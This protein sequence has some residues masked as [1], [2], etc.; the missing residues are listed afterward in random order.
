MEREVT[1]TLTC[2][3]WV[4]NNG[5]SARFSGFSQLRTTHADYV[6]TS[7]VS[8]HSKRHGVVVASS[9]DVMI[10]TVDDSEN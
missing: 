8:I 2:D 6:S 4:T 1:R 10:D 3:S 7:S 5:Q 9:S